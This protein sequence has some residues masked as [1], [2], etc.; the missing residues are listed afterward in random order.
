[1]C[2]STDFHLKL[3]LASAKA[4]RQRQPRGP[5]VE[6]HAD[7][8]LLCL[9][10]VD[11]LRFLQGLLKV[12]HGRLKVS[13][14]HCKAR[15]EARHRSMVTLCVARAPGLPGHSPGHLEAC[16]SWSQPQASGSLTVA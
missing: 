5:S 7:D 4:Q 16:V 8:G 9:V 3:L 10:V 15:W 14:F 2:G 13:Q 1:M 11:E 12:V 6:T